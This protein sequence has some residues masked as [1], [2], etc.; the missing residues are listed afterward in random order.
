MKNSKKLKLKILL[1]FFTVV[2]TTIVLTVSS[3]INYYAEK[4]LL[5]QMHEEAE[6]LELRYIEA[7][8]LSIFESIEYVF[9]TASQEVLFLQN[10]AAVPSY[11]FSAEPERTAEAKIME[12]Q[13]LHRLERI[14]KANP[15]LIDISIGSEIN[16]GYI[17]YPPVS[18]KAGYDSRARGWYK[19]AKAEPDRVIALGSYQASAGY[20]ALT[21]TKAICDESGSVIGVISGDINLSLLKEQITK[22]VNTDNGKKVLLVEKSGIISLDSLDSDNDFKKLEELEIPSLKGYKISNKMQAEEYFDNELFRIRA[23]PLQTSIFDAGL[24]LFTPQAALLHDLGAIRF[25][26][27]MI[28]AAAILV[29]AFF[30]FIISKRISMF[31][32][33]MEAALTEIAE[34]SGD[35]TASLTEQG[36]SETVNI[37][38]YFN[39]TLKKI[40][41]S[42]Q[43]VLK[44]THDMQKVSGTLALNVAETTDSI[45]EIFSN[46]KNV[47]Q[48]VENQSGSINDTS[49]TLEEIN[50]TIKRLNSDVE[51]QTQNIQASSQAVHEMVRSIQSMMKILAAN[52]ERI[53]QLQEKSELTKHSIKSAAQVTQDIS[54]ESD[55]LLEASG[56]IQHIASQTNL[57]AMNAAIEAAHA[58]EAGKGFAVVANEIR[59]LAEESSAQG[60]TITSVLKNLKTRIDDIAADTAGAEELFMKSFELTE[61]VKTQEDFIMNTMQKQAGDFEQILYAMK[62]IDTMTERVKSGAADMLVGSNGAAREMQRLTEITAAITNNMNEMASGAVQISNAAQEV[63]QIT[64]INKEN[65]ENLVEEINK[66]KI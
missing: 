61:S 11:L 10:T 28:L 3:S 54:S 9:A 33:S 48:Q 1:L 14:V 4:K 39:K 59:N 26:F 58:G 19:T 29:A 16:G 22:L 66:F 63:N 20:T 56:V 64:Q 60:K 37:A 45:V 6:T 65:I 35:L 34:G 21:I 49:G 44:N 52:K 27:L 31:F 5:K 25:N 32:E 41:H 18:R 17:Q 8:C 62:T 43:S 12:E 57:L 53:A 15:I 40:R 42:I 46:I 55:S 51:V 13:I 47:Q 7:L 36:T 50:K 24:I 23:I 30:S 2:L 38:Y